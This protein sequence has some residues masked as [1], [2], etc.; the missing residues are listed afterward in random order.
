MENLLSLSSWSCFCFSSF[1]PLSCLEFLI[2]KTS[3]FFKSEYYDN[4]RVSWRFNL[5]IKGQFTKSHLP[6]ITQ[7][8]NH[9]QR[10]KKKNE[11]EFSTPSEYYLN[12]KS[13]EFKE[14]LI[15]EVGP[16]QT[17]KVVKDDQFKLRNNTYKCCVQFWRFF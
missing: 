17:W 7:C 2:R 13:K 15:R 1:S 10:I 9:I 12:L 16:D 11:L 5:I 6:T 3:V 14:F 8:S 4:F